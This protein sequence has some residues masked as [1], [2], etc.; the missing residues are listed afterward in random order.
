LKNSFSVR[1]VAI[2]TGGDIGFPIFGV[3]EEEKSVYLPLDGK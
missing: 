2:D 1:H 3:N